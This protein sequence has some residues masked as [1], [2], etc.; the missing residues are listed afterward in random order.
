MQVFV[1]FIWQFKM[2]KWSYDD[3]QQAL[4]THWDQVRGV[5]NTSAAL[6]KQACVENWSLPHHH[7]KTKK[8]QNQTFARLILKMSVL[9]SV[10]F[11]PGYEIVHIIPNI[12][13]F[14]VWMDRKKDF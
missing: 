5:R 6:M 10:G 13:V 7:Q 4:S 1:L 3:S 9:F 11:L 2:L 14:Q 12:S 8:K